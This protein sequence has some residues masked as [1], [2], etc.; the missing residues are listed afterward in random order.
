MAAG[1]TDDKIAQIMAGLAVALPIFTAAN[2]VNAQ[3]NYPTKPVR[4]VVGFAPAGPADM[5]ARVVGDKLAEAWGQPVLIENATG[6]GANVAGDRAAKAAPDGYTLLMASNAQ[7]VIN[8]SLYEKM[9]FDPAKD[10]VTIS[11]SVF[12]TN[13]LVVHND[14]PAKSVQERRL[15]AAPI[16]AS[17]PTPRP[18]SGR[19]SI[20]P[21]SCSSRW[22]KSTSSTFP[23]AALLRP[24]P[25]CSAAASPC[26]SAISR[27]SFR[28]CATASC[29]RSPS[30][31][32]SDSQRCRTCRP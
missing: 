4:I 32:P 15:W 30:R 1:G 22:Q 7:I 17:S 13:L 5:I 2:L 10:L 27:R 26:S 8:P 14:V 21:P 6:A 19:R 16:R 29:G 9:S 28:W 11:Q 24:S 31:R 25:I 23:I 3:S 12:T 20:L 18:A